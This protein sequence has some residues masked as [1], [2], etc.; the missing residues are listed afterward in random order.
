MFDFIS[1][2]LV[3]EILVDLLNYCTVKYVVDLDSG[4][5]IF[6]HFCNPIFFFGGGGGYE[7]MSF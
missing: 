2:Q 6:Y 1:S 4:L 5:V 3:K 7:N